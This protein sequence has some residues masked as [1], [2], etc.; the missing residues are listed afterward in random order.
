MGYTWSNGDLITAERL[1]NTGSRIATVIVD[2]NDSGI[3]GTVGC[4]VGYAKYNNTFGGY[5]I[6]SPLF[7]HYGYKPAARIY[8]SVIL[9]PSGDDYKAFVFFHNYIDNMAGYTVTGD[10]STTKTEAHIRTGSN[11]WESAAYYGFEVTGDG[12]IDPYYDD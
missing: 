5:S 12:E 11:V 10:I 8:L 3:N 7:E 4:Y 2:F 6:E 1:N 9:P